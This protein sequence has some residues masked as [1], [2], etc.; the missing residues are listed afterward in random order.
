MGNRSDILAIDPTSSQLVAGN[1]RVTTANG[2]VEMPYYLIHAR[3]E[4]AAARPMTAWNTVRYFTAAVAPPVNGR[5][6]R[7][8]GRVALGW[9]YGGFGPHNT[10][11]ILANIVTPVRAYLEPGY[12]QV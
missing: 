4:D 7:L 2:I 8:L 10:G 3:L 11:M 1:R 6:I 12:G 5:A 9:V